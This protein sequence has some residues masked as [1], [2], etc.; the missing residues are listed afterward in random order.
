M[1]NKINS[2]PQKDLYLF[3]SI[4]ALDETKIN[5]KKNTYAVEVGPG[6]RKE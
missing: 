2:S 5:T 6:D 3:K 1:P 4:N